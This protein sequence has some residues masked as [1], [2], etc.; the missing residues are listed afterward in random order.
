MPTV[1]KFMYLALG[2]PQGSFK[3]FN[4]FVWCNV[5]FK[6]FITTIQITALKAREALAV[7]FCG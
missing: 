4:C 5:H 3:C 2:L 6:Q 1:F 7:L